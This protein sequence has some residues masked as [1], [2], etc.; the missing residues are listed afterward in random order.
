MLLEQIQEGSSMGWRLQ[1]A[2]IAAAE[3]GAAM[4]AAWDRPETRR[5]PAREIGE[6][7]DRAMA[8]VGVKWF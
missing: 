1:G 8:Y 2:E 7:E 6:D 3:A 5:R 4:E